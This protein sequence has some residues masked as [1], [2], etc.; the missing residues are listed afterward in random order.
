MGTREEPPPHVVSD[1]DLHRWS[2]SLAGIART[3]LAFTKSLYERERYEEV[4]HVA[5]EIRA[6]AENSST[7]TEVR[8]TVE[9]WMKSVGQGVPGYV[10][11][12]IAVGAVVT[13]DAGE[14]L[15]IQRSD[16]GI[17]LY[18]TGW[19]DVGYSASEVAV[20]EVEEETGIEVQVERLLGVFDGLRLGFTRVPLYSLVFLCRAVGGELNGH[21]LETMDVGWFTQDAL[22]HPT[23]GVDHWGPHAFAAIRGENVDVLYDVPR[24]RPFGGNAPA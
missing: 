21:P 1:S 14:I 22:P 10:T 8:A 9:E 3:G 18:P 19:A 20:K 24:D 5:A 23:A 11:P 16:S 13:N 17:W 15:L 7:T 6:V 12:K 2:E 4:L